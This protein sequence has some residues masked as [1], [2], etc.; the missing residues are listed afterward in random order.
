MTSSRA[1]KFSS[2]RTRTTSRTPRYFAGIAAVILAFVTGSPGVGRADDKNGGATAKADPRLDDA[3]AKAQT[4][5]PACS[6]TPTDADLKGAKG[7]HEAAKQYLERGVYD[8]AIQSWNEAYGFDCSRPSVFQNLSTAYE[9]KGDK[10]MTIAVLELLIARDATVDKATTEAK[11]ENLKKA[12][13][14]EPIAPPVPVDKPKADSGP[15]TPIDPNANTHLERPFGPAPW[16]VVGVGGAILVAGIPTLIVGRGKVSDAEKDC[17]THKHCNANAQ[18]EGNTGNVLTG[19]GA[20]LIGGGA[21]IAIGSIIWQFA[22]NGEKRVPNK[23]A[24]HFT[25]AVGPG[26]SGATLQRRF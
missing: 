18:S 23:E 12:L 5:Y 6:R 2:V 14:D 7:S 20:G 22:G 16:I 25:P 4:L 24:W 3:R 9:K 13:A 11:I 10:A 15:V 17:P 19:V 8:K 21:A 1:E 26:F